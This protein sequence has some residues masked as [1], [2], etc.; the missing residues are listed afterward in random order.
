MGFPPPGRQPRHPPS[1][2]LP[3]QRAL[4]SLPAAPDSL[5]THPVGTDGEGDPLAGGLGRSEGV[6]SGG[7]RRFVQVL[8]AAW[9]QQQAGP[10]GVVH[11]HRVVPVQHHQA[12]R[13]HLPGERR[14]LPPPLAATPPRELRGRRLRRAGSWGGTARW[15]PSVP[16]PPPLT[17]GLT[18]SPCQQGAG[19]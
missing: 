14:Q 15:A 3:G 16:A 18:S 2:R 7:E 6:G 17:G 19:W 8:A 5:A 4:L 11:L 10:A 12:F 1:G 13:C 9:R